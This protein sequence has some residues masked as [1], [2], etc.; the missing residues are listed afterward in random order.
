MVTVTVVQGCL[1]ATTQTQSN[2]DLSASRPASHRPIYN[3]IQSIALIVGVSRQRF[4][5]AFAIV[6][7]STHNTM[8]NIWHLNGWLSLYFPFFL[9][10][11]FEYYPSSVKGIFVNLSYKSEPGVINNN[12]GTCR[13]WI[14]Q[15][16][17][18][19]SIIGLIMN[20]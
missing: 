10:T 7:N 16:T 4:P 19:Y 17:Y 13:W 12:G 14:Y 3:Y 15:N 5:I 6:P 8:V 18:T 11:I 20:N 1:M 2:K 9:Q